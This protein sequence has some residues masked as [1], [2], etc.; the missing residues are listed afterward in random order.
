VN[1]VCLAE[2]DCWIICYQPPI[3]VPHNYREIRKARIAGVK[4]KPPRMVQALTVPRF[5]DKVKSFSGDAS[6]LVCLSSRN[7]K[8]FLMDVSFHDEKLLN[9]KT[10]TGR[11]PDT[12]GHHTLLG[13][14]AI[15]NQHSTR[16]IRSPSSYTL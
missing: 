6:F 15:Y 1:G 14:L 4:R 10:G 11:L 3:L 13:D 5:Y 7:L 8:I 9:D 2:R 12:T 16:S